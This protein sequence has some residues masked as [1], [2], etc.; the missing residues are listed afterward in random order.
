MCMN[1][2]AVAY[3]TPAGNGQ[4]V[5]RLVQIGKERKYIEGDCRTS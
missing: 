4:S 2:A 5:D 1:L 3:R